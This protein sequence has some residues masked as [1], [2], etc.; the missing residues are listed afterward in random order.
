MKKN[1]FLIVAA[2]LPFVTLHGQAKIEQILGVCGK[3]TI[4][5]EINSTQQLVYGEIDILTFSRVNDSSN[6]V[7]Y[8]VLPSIFESVSDFEIYDDTVWFCGSASDNTNLVGYFD[9]A[10]FPLSIIRY[11]P[12]TGVSRLTNIDVVGCRP[13][14]LVLIGVDYLGCTPIVN[15]IR[16]PSGWEVYDILFP[17]QE[18]RNYYFDDLTLTDTYIVLTARIIDNRNE[19]PVSDP[20]TRSFDDGLLWYLDYSI[21]AGGPLITAPVYYRDISYKVSYPFLIDK[22]LNDE[23]VTASIGKYTLNNTTT[24]GIIYS[25]YNVD[26]NLGT[27][28]MLYPIDSASL[29]DLRYNKYNFCAFPLVKHILPIGGCDCR[30][31]RVDPTYFG[32]PIWGRKFSPAYDIQSLVLQSNINAIMSGFD[33]SDPYDMPIFKF[34][35]LHWDDCSSKINYQSIIINNTFK[36]ERSARQFTHGLK[37]VNL[38]KVSS[39]TTTKVII[40][41]SAGQLINND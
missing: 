26:F 30:T 3:S 41:E 24:E 35:V 33:N 32:G 8:M 29:V 27:N 18:N 7:D 21:S 1:L 23:F 11:F 2:F 4:I 19:P 39:Q 14:Q 38:V 36:K 6:L 16:T 15:P 37:E 34:N 25:K 17:A 40:C 12:I 28:L 5:R 13:R 20:A 22:G 9:L 31:F 10:T